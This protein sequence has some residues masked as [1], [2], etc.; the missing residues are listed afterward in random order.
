MPKNHDKEKTPGNKSI[1]IGENVVAYI[2][3]II[4]EKYKIVKRIG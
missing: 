1:I 2:G 4:G 3:E